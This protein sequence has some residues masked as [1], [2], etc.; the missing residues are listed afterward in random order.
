MNVLIFIYLSFVAPKLLFDRL[1]KGKRHPGFLQRFGFQIPSAKGD[2]IWIHAVSVGEVKSVEPLFKELKAKE[3][4]AFFLITTTS[5]TGQAEAKRSLAEADAFAYLPVDLTWVVRRWIRKLRPKKFILVESDF[6]YNLLKELKK[7]GTEIFLVSGKVSLRSARRFQMFLSFSKKLFSFFDVVCVQNEDYFKRFEPFVPQNRLHI[8]GNLKLDLVA[9]KIEEKLI[10]PQPTI[11][12]SCTHAPEEEWL[13]DALY[14]GPWF[15]IL[16]P[17]HPERF[18]T[19]AQML[20]KKNIPFSR[21]TTFHEQ[22]R[23]RVLLVD[24]MGQLPICYAASRLCIVGGSFVDHV[25]GHNVLEPCLYGTPTLFGPF[26]H[27][28][29][30]FARRAID[31]GAGVRVSLE[32]VAK[33]VE[34]FFE[35]SSKEAMMKRAA[36]QVIEKNRG[37]T[38]R[39]LDAIYRRE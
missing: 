7:S 26:T 34:A 11:T 13:I 28:Q 35:D 38:L 18:E 31:C 33:T 32:S 9:K 10:F 21:W 22:S 25:G 6:W 15:I 8:T 20:L 29:N 1:F 2:V 3:K 14:E 24:A 23:G 36:L 30:E 17:R 16:A 27:G 4:E 39:T 37:S 12:L 5:A 19:V